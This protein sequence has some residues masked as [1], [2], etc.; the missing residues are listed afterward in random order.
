MKFKLAFISL[1]LAFPAA[2]QTWPV[3]DAVLQRIWE[4][5]ME[6]SRIAE[7]AQVLTDSIG[8]RLT[9][10]PGMAR[11]HEWAA[12]LARGWGVAARNEQYGVWV[13][14][15][16]GITHVDL[17]EP[18][19]R[20][21]DA[22]M[23]AWSPGTVGAVEGAVEIVP[24]WRS[25]EEGEAWLETV[26]GKFV[27]ISFPHPTCRPDSHYEEHG[28]PGALRRMR[29]ERQ[30]A[31]QAFR[32]RVPD[33]RALIARLEQAGAAG[34]LQSEWTGGTGANMIHA[35]S[36]ATIPDLDLGCEDYGLLWRLAENGQGPVIR[37]DAR[38]QFTGE[39]PV[40]NTLAT[41]RGRELPDEYVI[42]SAHFDS[43]DSA[44]GATDN[45]AGSVAVLEALRILAEAYPT[46][47]RSI[48]A[49]LW[50]GEEQGIH[51]SRRFVQMNPE[52]PANLQA[53]FNHDV[54]T[55][56]VESISAQGLV[57]AGAHLTEWISRVP[58]E[59]AGE[60]RLDVPGLPSAGSSDHAAFVCSGAPGFNLGLKSWSYTPHTWHTNLDTY[61]KLVMEE[62]RSNAVL[63]AM[64]AY[65]AA[66]DSERVG[67]AQREL[68]PGPGGRQLTWP[69]CQPG[70]E[71]P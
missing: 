1:F 15:E 12:D 46:P 69:A 3:E 22:T 34:I 52:V 67:R 5:G 24:A 63:M 31:F 33:T 70:Q 40:H 51:G 66:E 10:S 6:D 17:I 64:L 25:A 13:G 49:A 62:V 27:A 35:A 4:I 16:R 61:D 56:R 14:W 11:A 19:V 48:M 7:M 68:P 28:T 29:L 57:D 38:S 54:G 37:V 59:I 65:L 42:L 8:P 71:R 43:W 26:R 60:I 41:I 45:A 23:L 44:S 18:R 9:G 39:V 30:E 53:L 21:L 50:G 55:G 32:L 58:P 36:T 20:T 47:R 2:A